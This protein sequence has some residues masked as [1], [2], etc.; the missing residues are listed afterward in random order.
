MWASIPHKLHLTQGPSF[1]Q[2]RVSTSCQPETKGC[3][4]WGWPLF[5]LHLCLSLSVLDTLCQAHS[6]SDLAP[7]CAVFKRFQK[8]WIQSASCSHV[9]FFFLKSLRKKKKTKRNLRC[10]LSSVTHLQ[11]AVGNYRYF[12]TLFLAK[13]DPLRALWETE[14]IK[15]CFSH[16]VMVF[17]R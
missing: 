12:S 5:T 7:V 15:Q 6:D 17:Y 2:G 1:K 8:T 11:P 14:C 9:L 4:D 10:S 3:L 16:A 13:A